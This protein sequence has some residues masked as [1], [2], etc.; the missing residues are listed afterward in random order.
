MGA[1]IRNPQLDLFFQGKNVGLTDYLISRETV[2]DSYIVSSGQ[3]ENLDVLF[4]GQIAPNPNDLLDMVKFDQLIDYLKTKYEFIILD[5]APVMLVSDTLHLIEN[6]DVVLYVAKS[7]FTE[8]E[9]I[10]FAAGFRQDNKIK[11]MA[12]VLNGVLPQDTRYGTR[13]GYGYYSY[14]HDAKPKW[15]KRLGL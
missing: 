6:S 15:W 2:P 7:N 8:K 11:N 10:D 12:F 14:T 9:M 1:D 13:A 3:H 5:S 4:S